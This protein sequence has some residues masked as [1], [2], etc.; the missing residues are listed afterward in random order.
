MQIG[1]AATYQRV[2]ILLVRVQSGLQFHFKQQL[3][4]FTS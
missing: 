3:Y 4:G 1:K 2:V